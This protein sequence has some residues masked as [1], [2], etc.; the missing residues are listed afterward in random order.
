MERKQENIFV[1][2]VLLGAAISI[3]ATFIMLF[4]FAVIMHF[5]DLDLLW[6]GPLASVALAVG[7]QIGGCFSA[8]KIKSR[9]LFSG[10]AVA[11]VLFVII[12]VTGL[13]CNFSDF[14]M[15]TLIHAAIMFLS[16]GI[17]GIIGVNFAHKNKIK[18]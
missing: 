15:L 9:G 17:G 13:I 3:F 14:G 12:T 6:A 4:V 5:A 18:I 16:G 1:R 11:A 7:C 2:F 10:F 8:K